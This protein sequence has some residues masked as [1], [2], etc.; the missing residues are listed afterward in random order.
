[1][2]ASTSVAGSH[3]LTATPFPGQAVRTAYNLQ[4]VSKITMVGRH[5]LSC[6][7]GHR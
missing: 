2:A 3:S 6:R 1:M 5:G 7:T 4:G